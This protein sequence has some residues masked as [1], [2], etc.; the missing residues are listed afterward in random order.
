[1]SIFARWRHPRV[2]GDAL[3]VRVQT[4]TS[5]GKDWLAGGRRNLMPK[6][7]AALR[8]YY[9]LGVHIYSQLPVGRIGFR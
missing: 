7:P 1:M 8:E 4:V 2:F 9:L 5:S 6:Y 3:Y